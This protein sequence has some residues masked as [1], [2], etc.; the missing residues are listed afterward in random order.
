[1]TK[2]R[3]PEPDK[4][5]ARLLK[6]RPMTMADMAGK[7]VDRYRSKDESARRKFT[8]QA[9]RMFSNY[10]NKW[11]GDVS[12]QGYWV[13]SPQGKNDVYLSVPLLTAHTDTHTS[14]YTKTRP[15][16][17][18]H[19]YV[20]NERNRKLAEMC[21]EIAT[22]EMARMIKNSDLQ[23]EAQYIALATVSYRRINMH[24]LDRSPVVYEERTEMAPGVIGQ[25]RCLDCGHEFEDEDAKICEST[26][27]M[28]ENIDKVGETETEV[29]KDISTP[30][31]LPRPELEIPNP[32]QVQTAFHTQNF[33]QSPYVILRRT[34]DVQSAEYYYGIDLSSGQ[35]TRGFESK[36]VDDGQAEPVGPDIQYPL[37]ETG[38]QV[39][40]RGPTVED[41]E[42]W[43]DPCEYGLMNVDGQLLK[44]V[45]PTGLYLHVVGDYLVS[46]RP[47]NKRIEWIRVQAG[48]RPMSNQG[49][50]LIPLADMNDVVN[51][52][53][54]LEYAVLR[55]HGFPIR[56]L[57][58]KY[59]K[60]IPEALQTIIVDT[61]PEDVDLQRLIHTEQASN[62]SG[63][64]GVLTQKMQGYMQYIG[65]SLNP[66]GLPSDMRDVMGTATGASA[67]Q[68]MMAD[69]MG[70]SVQMRVEADIETLYSILEHLKMDERNKVL[71]KDHYHE[72]IVEMFF[73]EDLRSLFYFEPAK[74]SD[75]PRLDSVNV[76]K[77]QSF[78]QMSANLTGLRQFDP[79][80]FYDLI[81]AV[82]DA[83]NVDVTI[84]AGRRERNL[85]N[86]KIARVIELYKQTEGVD[87]E[88]ALDS[89]EAGKKLY[90]AITLKETE[91]LEAAIQS[92]VPPFDPTGL[93]PE[94]V[95]VAAQIWQEQMAYIAE[96]IEI[97]MCEWD[98]M[99][100]TYTDWMQSDEGQSA[101][102]PVQMAISMLYS[103]ALNMQE[104]KMARIAQQTAPQPE[105]SVKRDG[106]TGPG[107][108]RD[109]K[110]DELGESARGE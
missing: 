21:R 32:I 45:Y 46:H 68:E 56:L 42:M 23:K 94:E 4:L 110:V 37:I 74:G 36:V 93:A 106:S 69:R 83:L 67:I 52:T 66:T 64:L 11:L 24:E 59:L 12:D 91:V 19:P 89:I 27:C 40:Q 79:K 77:A 102:I 16:Y 8:R 71:L 95:P 38:T 84:G 33:Y 9:I 70:L 96:T 49:M 10:E 58:G 60:K 99:I 97:N 41:I 76:F 55:T 88:L 105:P 22:S 75:E 48:V 78:A 92:Q 101:P 104:K 18:A 87:Q 98:A 103:Y 108:P 26:E 29:E 44:D 30:V 43:L 100:E 81:N 28:S 25:Y 62:T 82:G 54:S 65:G 57:R 13:D 107:R 3:T 1:M 61:I 39:S 31:R 5:K 15:K 34:I 51:D 2:M 53:L 14:F 80:S 47:A 35:G 85:A 63:L 7:L 109:A 20:D 86:N 72:A 90:E 73:R 17:L 50:G 6:E